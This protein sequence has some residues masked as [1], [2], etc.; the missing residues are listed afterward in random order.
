MKCNVCGGRITKTPN[1][2]IGDINARCYRCNGCNRIFL[3]I[4]SRR[5]K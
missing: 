4:T 5:C 2:C 3:V 1:N